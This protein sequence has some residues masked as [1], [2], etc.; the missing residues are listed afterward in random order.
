M[1]RILLIYVVRLRLLYSVDQVHRKVNETD[2]TRQKLVFELYKPSNALLSVTKT[3]KVL[4]N[5]STAA[6]VHRFLLL[7]SE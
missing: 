4:Q 7:E 2:D 6:D 1:C 5:G 3:K